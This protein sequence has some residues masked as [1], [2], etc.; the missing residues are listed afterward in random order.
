[1]KK[2]NGMFISVVMVVRYGFSVGGIIVSRFLD[3]VLIILVLER[4]LVN[5]LV[6][7]I[8]EIIVRMFLVC[9]LMCF[10]CFWMYG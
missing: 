2:V 6:V 4:M 9:V 1:M 8:S 10:F 3:M 5:I 7:K